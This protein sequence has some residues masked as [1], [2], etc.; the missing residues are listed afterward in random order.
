MTA[1]VVIRQQQDLRDALV[2]AEIGETEVGKQGLDARD[3]TS[4]IELMPTAG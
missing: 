4:S 3:G 2:S 1:A